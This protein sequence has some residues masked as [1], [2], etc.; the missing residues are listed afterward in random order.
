MSRTF[1]FAKPFHV[2]FSFIL[3]MTIVDIYNFHFVVEES[4]TEK[5]GDLPQFSSKGTRRPRIP[6]SRLLLL[7]TKSYCLLSK[8]KQSVTDLPRLAWGK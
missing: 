5:F 4:E 7:I 6:L 8:N 3:R 2:H 1:Y